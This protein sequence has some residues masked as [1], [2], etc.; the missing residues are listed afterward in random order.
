MLLLNNVFYKCQ[1]G[2][3]EL[4]VFIDNGI[5]QHAFSLAVDLFFQVSR[6]GY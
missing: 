3:C 1:L 5:S 6:E 4:I 2:H